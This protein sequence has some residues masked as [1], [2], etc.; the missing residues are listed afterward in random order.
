MMVVSTYTG[1]WIEAI[2]AV[3]HEVNRA[4]CE[5]QGDLSQPRWDDAPAWQRES[6]IKGVRFALTHPDAKPSDSHESWLAEKR[7]DGWR[8]GPV[9]DPDRKEHPCFV[10]YDELPAAQKAKDHLFLGTV[11]ALAGHTMEIP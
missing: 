6:A 10:P 11:R 9:K 4:Y 8:Y 1:R 5:S 3:C 2:A 7:A